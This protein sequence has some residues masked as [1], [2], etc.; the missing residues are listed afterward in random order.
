[1]E[2]LISSI[3]I[4]LINIA[5]IKNKIE[6]IIKTKLYCELKIIYPP[7]TK[8]NTPEIWFIVEI[9]NCIFFYPLFEIFLVLN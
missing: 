1:M 5:D 2:S 6:L 7:I 4:K 9:M 8:P 3:F